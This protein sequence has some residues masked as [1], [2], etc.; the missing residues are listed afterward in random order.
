MKTDVPEKLYKYQDFTVQTLANLKQRHV[1]FSR[2]AAFND[3]FDCAMSLGLEELSD[4]GWAELVEHFLESGAFTRETGVA[5]GL[6]DERGNPTDRLKA[7]VIGASQTALNARADLNYT[8][9][10]VTCFSECMDDLLLWAHYGGGH[11][12]FCLEFSTDCELFERVHRVRYSTDVPRLNVVD[13]LTRPDGVAWLDMVLT[14]SSCWEYEKEWR[15]IHM[16]PDRP[17]TYDW[18]A[19]TGVYWG[20]MMPFVHKEIIALVLRGSGTQ[21]YQMRRREDAFRLE[22]QPVDYTPFRYEEGR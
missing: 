14:K 10:G 17:F 12:G 2:P 13:A 1:W 3:P 8:G 7:Q 6:L 9:R 15:A 21:L 5:Q 18:R 20:A 19:L 4:A 22:A 16:E 11:R